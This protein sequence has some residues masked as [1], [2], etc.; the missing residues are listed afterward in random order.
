MKTV[1]LQE[2]WYPV[3]ELFLVQNLLCFRLSLTIP[4]HQN[5]ALMQK[6]YIF[7]LKLNAVQPINSLHTWNTA[8]KDVGSQQLRFP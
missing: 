8:M 7:S 5:H 4:I 6:Q 2:V 1:A 3:R